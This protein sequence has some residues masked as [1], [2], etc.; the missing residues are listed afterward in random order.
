M[1]FKEFVGELSGN[2]TEGELLKTVIYSLISSLVVFFVLYFTILKNSNF[3][4]DNGFFLFFT[5][6]GF[7]FILPTIKQVRSYYQFSCMSGMMIGMTVGMV[8]GFIAGLFIGAT[9]GM[10]IGGTFGM[11][12]GIF[13]GVWLGSTCG[14]M[15]FMEGLMSGLMGGWMGAMTSVMLL[16]DHLKLGSVIIFFVC[17]VIT[18]S[19]DYMVYIETKE[20]KQERNQSN[21]PIILISGLLT[22]ISILLM[23]FAP[24]SLL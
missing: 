9:N 3:I 8:A 23:A 1:S 4:Q 16:N 5:I 20:R 17:L 21:I 13:L 6:L 22:L 12:V 2:R 7:S 14:V 15:G 19:L 24:R 11:I 10:F 18:I